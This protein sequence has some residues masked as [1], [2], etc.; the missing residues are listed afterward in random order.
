MCHLNCRRHHY[1]L[2][3]K[4][5][6]TWTRP[7][8]KSSALAPSSGWASECFNLWL[9]AKDTSLDSNCH[10]LCADPRACSLRRHFTAKE[11]QQALLSSWSVSRHLSHASCKIC[12]QAT[13]S[14]SAP[15]Q[16]CPL[17]VSCCCCLK[18]SS[19]V[20]LLDFLLF[21][22]RLSV[23][24]AHSTAWP[25]LPIL[26]V[27]YHQAWPL[28]GLFLPVCVRMSANCA[29]CFGRCRPCFFF[30]R[31]EVL[32]RDALFAQAP[33]LRETNIVEHSAFLELPFCP[34]AVHFFFTLNDGNRTLMN[35]SSSLQAA[36]F[37]VVEA[38]TDGERNG[39][40]ANAVQIELATRVNAVGRNVHATDTAACSVLAASGTRACGDDAANGTMY[41]HCEILF[42]SSH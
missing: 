14:F 40:D 13:G 20:R 4:L 24:R 8:A 17:L 34:T 22:T 10:M 23:L 33:C 16:G 6:C 32:Y 18:H 29:R 25:P 1:T 28:H 9:K 31:H 7:S 2:C 39:A 35:S 27:V 21:R 11:V 19:P 5:P 36:A 12:H 38:V 26:W 42:R 3:T 30:L 41:K 37:S 15:G